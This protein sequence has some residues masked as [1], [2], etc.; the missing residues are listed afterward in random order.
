MPMS[1]L[2]APLLVADVSAARRYLR[3]LST[4]ED[5]AAEDDHTQS[6]LSGFELAVALAACEAVEEVARSDC[7][8]PPE[9]VISWREDLSL[10][11]ES[12]AAPAPEASVLA[13]VGGVLIGAVLAMA[14]RGRS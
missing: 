1:W 3:D 9:D 14:L 13:D 6:S 7:S 4:A 2:M 10:A 5:K 12:A 8:P 11:A